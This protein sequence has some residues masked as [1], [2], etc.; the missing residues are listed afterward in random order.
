MELVAY[1]DD[2]GTDAGSPYLVVAGF[3]A[4]VEQWSKFTEEIAALDKKFE[5]PPFHARDFEK[6]GVGYGPY[7]KWAK[8]KRQHYLNRFLGTIR[9]RCYKSFGTLLEMA[10]YDQ[11]I[12][13]FPAI[14][15]HFY[16]PFAFAAVNTM[17]AVLQWRDATY[18]G[19]PARF[20]F[21]TGNKNEGQLKDVAKRAFIGYPNK[22]VLFPL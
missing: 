9:R 11:Y 21:D 18:P 8:E 16:A 1:L 13:R 19:V 10:V 20:V 4:N 17:H 5:A 3:A 15:E 14:Q 22:N 6:A 7:S 12:R 2:S